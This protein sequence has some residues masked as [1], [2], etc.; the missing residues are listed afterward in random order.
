MFDANKV[1]GMLMDSGMARSSQSRVQRAV[2]GG[3]PRLDSALQ[4]LSSGGQGGGGGLAGMAGAL[5][6]G[7]GS[8]AGGAGGLAGIAGAL[9]GGSGSR[10]GASSGGAMALLGTLASAA[11]QQL[12]SGQ[13]AAQ[14]GLAEDTPAYAAGPDLPDENNRATVMIRAMIAAATAAGEI[15]PQERQRILGRLAEAGADDD[16]KAFVRE[17]FAKPVDVDAIVREINSPHTAVEAYAASLFAIDI[18]TPAEAAY[19]RELARG[20]GLNPTLVRELHA[21]LEVP[22]TS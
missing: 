7:G 18:D 3:S 21:S 13:A 17:E 16:A 6:G 12:G 9:L 14:P 19:M 5:L 1:L 8:R 20:L 22:Q 11:M 2:G 4:M 10:G 15:D